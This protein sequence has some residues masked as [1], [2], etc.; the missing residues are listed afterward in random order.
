MP[1]VLIGMALILVLAYA[2]RWS[3]ATEGV[4]Y[5]KDSLYH[6]IIVRDRDNIRHLHFDNTYQSAMNLDN[7][8]ELVF[9][10]TR[11]LH[12]ARVF[13]PEARS[14][15]FLGLGGGSIQKSFYREYPDLILDVAELDPDVVKVAKEYFGVTED[16]RLKIHTVDGRLFLKRTDKLYDLAILD[17]F[18]YESIPFHLTTREFLRELADRLTPDGVVAANVIGAVTGPQSRLFRSMIRTYQEVFSQ[19]Y[20]FPVGRFDGRGDAILRNIVVVATKDRERLTPE[21]LFTRAQELLARGQMRRDV[22]P[23]VHSLLH[24]TIPTADVPVLTDDYAPVDNLQH[25]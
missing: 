7:P 1:G 2:S 16:S 14:V 20:I 17:A 22:S 9:N 8:D 24:E 11:Y 12:L 18:S 4:L 21:E 3:A 23:L 13:A 15:L 25:F 5:E 6:K 19:V 10:Y